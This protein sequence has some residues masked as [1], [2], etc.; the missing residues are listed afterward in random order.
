MSI[1]DPATLLDSLDPEQ[2]RQQLEELDRQQSA[3]RVLLRAALVRQ[4]QAMRRST[5]KE[6]NHDHAERVPKLL[7]KD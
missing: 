7:D 1:A 4:R 5:V 3:L 2:L 6:P